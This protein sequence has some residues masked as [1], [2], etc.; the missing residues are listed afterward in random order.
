[1]DRNLSTRVSE[2]AERY[3]CFRR[4]SVR[5]F[6]AKVSGGRSC[7]TVRRLLNKQ[8]RWT[9]DAATRL[10]EHISDGMGKTPDELWIYLVSDRVI[11]S[12]DFSEIEFGS[13]FHPRPRTIRSLFHLTRRHAAEASGTV[14]FGEM[15]LWLVPE[16]II[17][18]CFATS[19]LS[20]PGS[21]VRAE[22]ALARREREAFLRHP[23]AGNRVVVLLSRGKLY[24]GYRTGRLLGGLDVF[25]RREVLESILH[26][27]VNQRL[28][29]LGI[30]E[31][32]DVGFPTDI[33][34]HFRP[35]S[36]VTAIDHKLFIKRTCGSFVRVVFERTGVQPRDARL[37]FELDRLRQLTH[38]VSLGY[39]ND[40]VLKELALAFDLPQLPR[41]AEKGL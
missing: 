34:N 23:V 39:S 25:D 26:D 4:L 2:L 8:S 33:A 35:Y 31:D 14:C 27:A 15:P 3:R 38:F 19:R 36:I 30:V 18:R 24:A 22:I 32:L 1:M 40:A 20:T 12:S 21:V 11:T 41:V 13:Y 16:E 7:S 29:E 5:K 9:V 37:D 10:V 6:S 28:I 17:P